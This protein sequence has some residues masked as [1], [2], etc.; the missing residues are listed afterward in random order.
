MTLGDQPS[1]PNAYVIA[2]PNGAG[3]TTFA[4]EFL[5]SYA[6]C[7][8]FINADLIAQGLSPFSPEAAAFR[9]GRLVLSE[10]AS[11]AERRVDFGFETTLAGRSYMGLIR[12]LKRRGY[13]IH[14]FYL[15]LPN[16]ELALSRIQQRVLRGG[17]GVPEMD[18]RR[19]FERST[20]NFLV[21]YTGLA[22]SWMLFDNSGQKPSLIASTRTGALVIMQEERYR[23]LIQHYGKRSQA[24]R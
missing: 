2:G 12:D 14:F 17:H 11:M 1:G 5:P 19:R 20:G 3:K 15:W 16:V 13:Q 21:H 24:F 18:V 9:A 23:E 8:N 10:I 7:R 6:Q 4:R 22:N